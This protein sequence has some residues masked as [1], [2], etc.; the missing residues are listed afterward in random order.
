MNI[1]D[2]WLYSLP[3]QRLGTQNKCDIGPDLAAACRR[4]T[5]KEIRWHEMTCTGVI[6]QCTQA[7]G[8]TDPASKI[9]AVGGLPEVSENKTE[10]RGWTE[11]TGRGT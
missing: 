7:L 9:R 3:V 1:H 10:S 4:Q 2:L 5:R 6:K 8:A 11:F